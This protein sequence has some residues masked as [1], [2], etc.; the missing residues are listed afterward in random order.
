MTLQLANIQAGANSSNWIVDLGSCRARRFSDAGTVMF[1]AVWYDRPQGD[2]FELSSY[3]GGG[4][5]FEEVKKLLAEAKTEIT[6]AK[7]QG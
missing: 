3:S 6:A 7:R 1:E 2:G 4:L 5:D